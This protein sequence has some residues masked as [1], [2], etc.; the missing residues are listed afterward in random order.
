I[1]Q[2]MQRECLLG[3]ARFD[4]KGIFL[5]N[6]PYHIVERIAPDKYACCSVLEYKILVGRALFL[7]HWKIVPGDASMVI[8]PFDNRRI[9]VLDILNT[10]VQDFNIFDLVGFI[11]L[12]LEAE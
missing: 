11:V 12:G 3:I 6:A 8:N 2:S 7:I 1:Q 5:L 10:L 9:K 4:A